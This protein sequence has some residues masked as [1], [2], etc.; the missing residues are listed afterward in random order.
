M[1][2][3]TTRNF[4][5]KFLSLVLLCRTSHRHYSKLLHRKFPHKIKY[6]F[7]TRICRHGHANTI[8]LSFHAEEVPSLLVSCLDT[9]SVLGHMLQATHIPAVVSNII[10]DRHFSGRNYFPITE[11]ELSCQSKFFHCRDRSVGMSAEI[12]LLSGTDSPFNSN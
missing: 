8:L 10:T 4:P 9:R 12:S 3:K 6:F 5:R 2:R 7:T 1:V 11:T